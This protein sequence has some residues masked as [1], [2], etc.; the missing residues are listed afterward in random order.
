VGAR[1]GLKAVAERK[2]PAFASNKNVVVQPILTEL[3]R[4]RPQ[5]KCRNKTVFCLG[6]QGCCGHR[7]QIISKRGNKDPYW[8]SKCVRHV[9]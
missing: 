7:S 9:R 6:Y 1:S 2:I 8:E 5:N 4:L 3:P